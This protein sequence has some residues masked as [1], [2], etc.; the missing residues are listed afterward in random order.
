MSRSGFD[1]LVLVLQ[2]S[3]NF[4]L[5]AFS[6][7][8]Q[9]SSSW[10]HGSCLAFAF[11]VLRFLCFVLHTITGFLWGFFVLKFSNCSPLK[12][13]FSEGPSF[14]VRSV[15]NHGALKLRLQ[16][17]ALPASLNLNAFS[18]LLQLISSW[19]HGSCSVFG[20]GVLWFFCFVLYARSGIFEFFCLI[21]STCF[22]VKPHFFRRL[23]IFCTLCL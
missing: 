19:L 2:N 4:I 13:I 21:S 14:F 23:F 9:L 17:V 15:C 18:I 1:C 7:S 6:I 11:G 3:N 12:L 20:L 5:N 16:V 8:L 10:L 22:P